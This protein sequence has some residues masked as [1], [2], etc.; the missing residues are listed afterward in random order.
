P[1][2]DNMVLTGCNNQD[3]ITDIDNTIECDEDTADSKYPQ[4]ADMESWEYEEE[5][6][7]SFWAFTESDKGDSFL[8][9]DY[10]N[11][12][13]KS[14][15]GAA[16]DSNCVH[17]KSLHAHAQGEGVESPHKDRT[18]TRL[19]EDNNLSSCNMLLQQQAYKKYKSRLD[20]AKALQKS[21][22]PKLKTAK[23][24][25]GMKERKARCRICFLIKKGAKGLP[26]AW[27]RVKT[28]APES[29]P[30]FLFLDLP[31]PST[32]NIPERFQSNVILQELKKTESQDVPVFG[33]SGC[34][35]TRP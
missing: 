19:D 33:V 30:N 16:E 21:V 20:A 24:V 22:I 29:R 14:S 26:R 10:D 3:M 6:A 27:R 11:A 25:I 18:R 5:T 17:P 34:G 7:A 12:I 35:K 13:P 28:T 9:V 2:P 1:E 15:S 8:D 31:T 32:D 4:A 23:R